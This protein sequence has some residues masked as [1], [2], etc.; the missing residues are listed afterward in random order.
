MNEEKI[1]VK[2]KVFFNGIN[3]RSGSYMFE[4]MSSEQLAEVAKGNTLEKQAEN[5]SHFAEL[6]FRKQNKNTSH[7]G[8][9]EGIDPSKLEEAGWGVIFPAV[10]AGGEEAMRQEAIR[11]AL[12]PLLNLRKAQATR[13]EEHY[14]KE[15]RGKLGYHPGDSKQKY[16]ALLGTGPGPADPER[17]PYYL[18]IVGSPEEIPFHVQYQIDVQ[19]AV[20]RIYFDTIEEYANYARSVVAAE[21][22]GLALAREV[23]F[24]GVANPDDMATQMS[25]KNLVGPLADKAESWDEVGDWTVSR[26][27]D[28]RADKA[29]VSELFGGP[30]TPALIFS[31]SHGMAFERGDP[32][33]ER[34]QGALLL[35]D[36]TGPKQWKG[37]IGEELYLSGDD[38][39][40]DAGLL[41]LISFNFACYG[42]GTP[43]FDEFSKQAFKQRK[44]IADRAFVSGLH[45]KLLGHPKGGALASL[46]HVER[47]WGYSF[48]WGSGRRGAAEPQ[49]AVFESTLESL[50]KGMPV[51]MAVDYFNERYA[52][53]ASD[54][55]WELEQLEYEADAVDP[56]T[57][58]T[59]WTSNNDAR[60]YAILGD[61]AVR[62]QFG[63]AEGGRERAAID[64]SSVAFGPASGPAESTGETEDPGPDND[65]PAAGAGSEDFGLFG[66]DKN[67]GQPE[68]G[69]EAPRKPGRLE[70]MVAK[71]ADTL[72]SA[73]EDAATLEVRTYVSSNANAAAAADRETLARE[74]DLRAFT[75]IEIDGDVDVI[76]PQVDGKID[77]QLWELH[78]ELVKQAQQ[79]RAQTL[80]TVLSALSG[81]MKL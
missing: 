15:Y 40:S 79:A 3:A 81:L 54:L 70:A 76:V 72:G 32:L 25:R 21:T 61:P 69:D 62:L 10:P 42:G 73:I 1:N 34:H 16:L 43:K 55:S 44:A 67:R 77:T 5:K 46:G 28:E 58:A 65:G 36:W 2:E 39:R 45:R 80:E 19:Y 6:K 75:R 22:G 27:F 50:M 35:Q 78:L 14:Y 8:V 71:L 48:M 74:G 60:G 41:G 66:R 59:M 13:I 64:I 11:E 38:L 7:Y 47:A 29:H 30:K 17:V 68:A 51:G 12:S 57:L 49:L 20:G 24:V 18:L 37:P 53:M 33:Q 56:Y 31:G 4:P 26:Y 23:A 63:G 52:E 9:K